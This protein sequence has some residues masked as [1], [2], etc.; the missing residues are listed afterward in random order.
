MLVG[1]RPAAR[2]DTSAQR[3]IPPERFSHAGA[4]SV[5]VMLTNS[6]TRGGLL[7]DAVFVEHPTGRAARAVP[8]RASGRPAA[9]GVHGGGETLRFG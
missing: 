6:G 3:P 4:M 8:G 9:R 1:D 2:I 5:E 7:Q